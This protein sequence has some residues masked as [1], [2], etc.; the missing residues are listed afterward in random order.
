MGDGPGEVAGGWWLVAGGDTAAVGTHAQEGAAGTSA[1]ARRS[2]AQAR[3][4]GA[5]A[6]AG[7]GVLVAEADDDSSTLDCNVAGDGR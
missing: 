5:G 1:A 7:G 2:A 3:G 4:A 6:G